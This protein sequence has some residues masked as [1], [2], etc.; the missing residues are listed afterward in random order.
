LYATAGSTLFSALPAQLALAQRAVGGRTLLGTDYRS[1]VCIYLFGGND[2]FN[3]LAP[4]SGTPRLPYEATRTN[5]KIAPGDLLPLS[6]LAGGMPSD[7]GVYGLYKD[8]PGLASL[9]NSGKAAVI[10]NVGPLVRPTTKALYGAGSVQLPAQL[11]SHSDQTVQWQTPRADATNRLGWGGQLADIFFASN[12]NQVLSMNV[13]LFGENVFQAG[14]VVSPYF[15]SPFGVEEI[16]LI[17]TQS[18]WNA[19]RRA[20]FDAIQALNKE[21]IFERAYAGKVDRMRQTTAQVKDALTQIPDTN[22]LF[23]PFWTELGLNPTANPRPALPLLSRQLLMAARMI[24][25]RNTLGMSR[26]LFFAGIGGFD[27]HDTQLA[28]HPVLL[29]NLSQALK[30]FYDVLA[31]PQMNIAD[32]VTAFTA[33]E[34]G[35][36]LSNNGDGTDHGWGSHHFVV[37]GSVRGQRIYGRMPEL[38]PSNQNGD[39]A[40]WGQIIPTLAADQYAATLAS[41]FGLS[42][43]D[44]AVIFPNLQHYNSSIMAIQGADL[45]FMNT[46]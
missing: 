7:G 22:A 42:S 13:S 41:W 44:R 3:M 14:N 35:R 31:S 38:S 46:L 45:G 40:G 34:F 36:T 11:F 5:L 6:P 21:H 26:Q 19:Q 24:W 39:D 9:F 17:S 16:D 32:R 18:Q 23:H 10:A 28:D 29:R 27:T 30:A 20:T 25:L 8:M 4:I 15:M 37:G 33:S 43:N 12:Q 2:P 1:L